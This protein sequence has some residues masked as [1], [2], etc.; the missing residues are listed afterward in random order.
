MLVLLL[1]ISQVE[2]FVRVGTIFGY[3]ARTLKSSQIDPGPNRSGTILG[4]SVS[5][6]NQKSIA[7]DLFPEDK[8]KSVLKEDLERISGFVPDKIGEVTTSSCIYRTKGGASSR[9]TISLLYR[10]QKDEGTAKKILVALRKPNKGS[11]VSKLGD[12]A[13]FNESANQLTVR[14]N[15]KLYTITVPEVESAKSTS[16]D[17]AIEI[18]KIAV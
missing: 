9:R 5:K 13:Y 15:K 10:E 14:V 12:E 16:K 18:A 1:V 11:D 2:R 6:N 3:S 4:G 17:I 7:C 8:M